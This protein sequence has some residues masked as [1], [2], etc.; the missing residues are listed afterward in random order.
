MN[1]NQ[2]IIFPE[3]RLE[4]I[5]AVRELADLAYQRKHW[6]GGSASAPR[7]CFDDVVHWLFDDTS[8]SDA[9]ASCVGSF[10]IS[11]AELVAITKA[12]RALD[13]MF[14]AYGFELVDVDYT[15]KPEWSAVISAAQEA[16]TLLDQNAPL[17]TVRKRNV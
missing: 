6:V 8:L 11:E 7:T 13:V 17:V 12:M 1:D 3:I 15:F 2:S 5:G 14:D 9:P 4:V 10:L 16:I